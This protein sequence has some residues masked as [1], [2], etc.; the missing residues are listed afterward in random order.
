MTIDKLLN[1]IKILVQ[2]DNIQHRINTAVHEER[3]KNLFMMRDWLENL[4]EVNH[5]E[6]D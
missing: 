1:E 6:G 2:N 4:K 5:V 3:Q